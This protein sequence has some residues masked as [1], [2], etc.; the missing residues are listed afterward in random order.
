[1]QQKGGYGSDSDEEINPVPLEVDDSYDEDLD[2]P[3]TKLLEEF[4]MIDAS[5][6]QSKIVN[7]HVRT[8]TRSVDNI[9]N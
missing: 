5:K 6:N 3:K 8:F 2:G 4:K 7:L 1:M 9:E